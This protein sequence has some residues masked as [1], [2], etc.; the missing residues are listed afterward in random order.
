MSRDAAW[1]R[2]GGSL[3]QLSGAPMNKAVQDWRKAAVTGE[4]ADK[5][6]PAV[7]GRGQKRRAALPGSR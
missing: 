3:L 6:W 2:A 4:D 5:I 7:D 1:R